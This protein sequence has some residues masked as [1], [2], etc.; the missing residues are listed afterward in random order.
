MMFEK[1]IFILFIFCENPALIF[2]FLVCFFVT[3]S[4]SSRTK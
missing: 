1:Y 2:R 3:I 4:N